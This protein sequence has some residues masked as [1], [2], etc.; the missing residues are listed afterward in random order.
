MNDNKKNPG[1]SR[2]DKPAGETPGSSRYNR[3]TPE[4]TPPMNPK[5]EELDQLNRELG[6]V[7]GIS[8]ADASSTEPVSS[9]MAQLKKERRRSLFFVPAI[10]LGVLILIAAG[11]AAGVYGLYSAGRKSLL[12]H[13]TEE[14]VEITAPEDATLEE[15]GNV[16]TWKGKKYKRNENIVAILGLG[17]DKKTE[18]MEAMIPGE[19]GQSDTIIVG[20]LDV[21]NGNLDLINISRD[22]MAD[23]DLYNENGEYSATERMQICLAY[24]YGDGKEKSCENARKAVSRLLYGIPIDAYFSITVPAI[25]ALND[26]IGGVEVEVLEDLS[27]ADPALTKGARVQLK[28]EQVRTYV[29][30]RDW[31]DVEA[32]NGRM[33]RQRQYMAAFMR[34]AIGLMREN[35]STVLTIYEAVRANMVT[36]LN[37]SR[38]VY[39][40]RLAMTKDF[41]EQ[42]II[43]VP[44]TIEK[45]TAAFGEE[46]AEYTVD[47]E[48]LYQIILDV[49]YQEVQ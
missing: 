49:F 11:A 36:D 4:S 22:S 15:N 19:A 28:G 10:V 16:V 8:G 26:S 37:L 32:N 41:S 14:G 46:H 31:F 7:L 1:H 47:E 2:Y 33:E 5:Q 21:E 35:I 30:S 29:I 43:T 38:M 23:I 3:P 17:I 48:A 44:G 34:K 24:A 12:T 9:Q 45:G 27:D 40:A 6:E 39:L 13:K 42:N 25:G 20:A 18:G